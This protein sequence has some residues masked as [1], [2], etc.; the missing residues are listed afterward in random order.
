M[1]TKQIID[2]IGMVLQK[3]MTSRMCGHI[4]GMP[5]LFLCSARAAPP[6]VDLLCVE[7]NVGLLAYQMNCT[8][9]QICCGI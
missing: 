8:S 4:R 2:R 7:W 3:A 9:K 6:Q 1:W 5:T